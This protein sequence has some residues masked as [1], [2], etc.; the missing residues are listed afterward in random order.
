MIVSHKYRFIFLK[1]SKTAGTSVEIALSKICGPRDI[2]TQLPKRDRAIRESLGYPGAQNHHAPLSEYG[3]K[4]YKRLLY[5][6]LKPRFTSHSTA[7][8]AKQYLPA[9]I[10][11]NYYKFSIERN[12]WDRTMSSFFWDSKN[13]PDMTLD[14]YLASDGPKR[15]K[16]RGLGLYSV[17]GKVIADFIC[18]FENLEDDLNRIRKHL[19]IP[20]PLTLPRTKAQTRKDRRHYRDILNESQ[21]NFIAEFFAEEIKLYG[22]SY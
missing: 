9:D 18:R 20:E 4:D 14:D 13:N 17:N 10:W 8:E 15:L 6:K 2:I 16:E 22:Y 7:A 3:L 5:G 12:P 19:G 21:K 11:N 1:T